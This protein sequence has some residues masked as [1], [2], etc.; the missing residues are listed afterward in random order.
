MCEPDLRYHGEESHI[1]EPE[2]GLVRG[3]QAVDYLRGQ[4][5]IIGAVSILGIGWVCA[6]QSSICAG[7]VNPAP[8]S[9]VLDASGKG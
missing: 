2:E 3:D 1:A 9:V 7:I 6:V 5:P 4:R 8:E